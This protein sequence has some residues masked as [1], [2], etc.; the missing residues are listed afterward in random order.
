[1]Y[2]SFIDVL[3]WKKLFAFTQLTS[4]IKYYSTLCTDKPC[5]LGI[6]VLFQFGIPLVT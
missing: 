4:D 3:I 6:G 2:I 5:G 1:M